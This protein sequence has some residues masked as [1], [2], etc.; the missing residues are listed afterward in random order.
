MTRTSSEVLKDLTPFEFN[1][2]RASWAA[3]RR[4]FPDVETALFFGQAVKMSWDKL[5]ELIQGLFHS[6]V[7][8]ALLEG[9]HSTELQSYI[10]HTAP[11]EVQKQLKSVDFSG[12]VPHAEILPQMWEA[13]EIGVANSIAEVA[14]KLSNVLD[15]LPGTQG[16]MTFANL[17]QLNR[18]RP[19]I[20]DYKAR[21]SHP[22]TG[23]NLVVFDVSGSMS[24]ATV[25]RIAGDVVAMAMKAKAGLCI[26]SDTAKHWEPGTF[27]VADVMREA[28]FGGTRYETLAPLFDK[29]SWDVVITIADY[30]SSE[31]AAQWVRK[32]SSG[33]IEKL[34]DISLVKTPTYLAV[35]LGQ[36]AKSVE[37]MLLSTRAVMGSRY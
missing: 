1:G 12:T 9:Y 22:H 11:P 28:E 32:H 16:E 5:N 21:I 37:P 35:V 23:K 24:Q 26:V 30:D 2:K 6:D 3:M 20:G 4:L 29:Q 15:S 19:T 10:I 17:M 13:L 18:R 33:T 31:A 7:L 27:S 8:D 25:S 14:S 34:L 36:L